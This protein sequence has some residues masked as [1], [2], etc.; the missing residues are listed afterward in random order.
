MSGPCSDAKLSL[1]RCVVLNSEYRARSWK[2]NGGR[3][4]VSGILKG[5]MSEP[6]LGN[7]DADF[8]DLEIIC[9]RFPRN[10]NYTTTRSHTYKDV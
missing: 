5:H 8:I 9:N 7:I 3:E 6:A 2:V 1:L 4:V 10:T